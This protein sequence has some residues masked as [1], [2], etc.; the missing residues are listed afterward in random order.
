MT[1]LAVIILIAAVA[2]A[3]AAEPNTAIPAFEPGK[4]VRVDIGKPAGEILVYVPSDYNDDCNRPAIFYYHGKGGA[5]ST[6][7]LQTATEGKG[8]VIV[9]VEFAPTTSEQMNPGQYRLYLQ[10]EIKNLAFVRHYLQSWL[11]IDP[12]MTVLA[13]GSRGGWLAADILNFRP[14]LA[15][16]AVITGAGYQEWL[17]KDAPSLAGKYV[18]IG[19]GE[20]DVNLGAA[21]K[22]ARYFMNCNADVT[23]ELYAGLGHNWKPDSPKLQNWL[24]DLRKKLDSSAAKKPV[25]ES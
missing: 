6:K 12:K 17:M 23:F 7:W 25:S 22:A 18:Y 3:A 2:S 4:E 13:G 24:S 16:G 19:A 8:F 5:L 21:K 10:H 20:T 11:K 15:A 14:L 1:R 9:S